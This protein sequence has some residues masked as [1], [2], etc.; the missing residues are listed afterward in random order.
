MELPTVLHRLGALIVLATAL[1]SSDAAAA[2][3]R[4][5]GFASVSADGEAL[6]SI[7]IGTPPG[8]NG[9]TP[10]LSL[11]YHHR[12]R[13][14]LLGVGWSLSGLSQI[15]RCARTYSQDGVAEPPTRT[16]LDRFCLDGQR[17]VVVNGVV[18]QAPNAEYRTEIES[19]ARI[20]AVNGPSVNGPAYFI[21]ERADGRIYEYGATADSSIEGLATPPAGG[22]RTWALNRIRDRSGNVI[23]Y[24]YTE[25]T[26]S[27][28]F[29]IASIRYNS[30][31]SNGVEASHEVTFTYKER[32]NR[33]IDSGFVAGMP[34][35]Q[36]VRLDRIDVRFNGEVLRSYHLAYE[37]ALSASGRSRLARVREC[38]PDSSDCLGPTNFEWR[39]GGSGLSAPA[40]FSA[41]FPSPMSVPAGGIWNLADVNGDGRPDHV[42]AVGADPS[43][44]TIRYRLSLADGTFG[45]AVNT[46]IA[47]SSGIGM[48]F[49]ANG[50]GRAD[51]LIAAM[52][53]RWAIALGSPTG[54][55]AA[56]DTGIGI[57]SG[58]RDFR[59]ADL[60]GDG[61]GDIAW[62]ESPASGGNT[63]KVRA[64]FAKPT[65]GFGD[66][67]TLYSQWDALGFPQ[68]EGGHFIG[69]PG[70][71]IDL[72]GD[73]AE[74]LLLN[75]NYT[76]AR[77]SD[78][79]YA[80]DRP[81][82]TFIGGVP[83]DF[84]DDGCT[85][86]AY[87]HLSS[88]TLRVRP[89]AC[90]IVAPTAD[91][92]GPAWTGN[93]ELQAIDWNGDGRD[94]VLLRGPAN[95]LVALSLGDA[96]APLED[97]GV[98][99]E[100]A[101]AIAGRDLDGDGLQDVALKSSNQV[102]VRFRNGQVPD[103][104]TSVADG[105][106]VGA[107][108]T[109][110]PLTDDAVHAAGSTA[111]WPDPH[112]Q[113]NELVVSRLRTTD[114]S[115]EGGQV[116]SNFR[117]E[118]LRGNVQGR[119]SLGFRKVTRT[120]SAGG[121][122]LSSVLTRRQD[123][124]FTGLPVSVLLQRT[125]GPLVASS[126]YRWSKLELGT[127]MNTRRFPYPSSITSRRFGIG[128][129][130]DGA[131]I[132]RI[133]R[134]IAS[135]D[136]T[137][138]LITDET[139]ATTETASGIHAGSSASVRTQHTD[140]F[141]DVANWCIGRS[142]GTEVTASHT[143]VGGAPIT[144][145]AEQTWN[146]SKCRPTR[147]RL[148]P[149]D[150]Q[151]QVTHDLAYDVFG[152]L[153]SEKITGA[154][155]VAR[156]VTTQWDA[157]GQLPT[158]VTNPLAQASRYSWDEAR[159]LPLSFTDPNGLSVRWDYDA[160]GQPLRETMPDGTSTVWER[161]TCQA[162][163][164]P[165]ARYQIR[166]DELDN[167]GAVRST[168]WLEVDQHDRGF[169]LETLEPGG[170]RAVSSV[171][172]D[173]LGR[174]MRRHLPR[175]YGDQVP[176]YQSF[177]YD[178]IGRL[179]TERLVGA[180]GSIEQLR[181]VRYDGHTATQ[182][183]ALGRAQSGTRNAWGPLA[184]VVDALG[185]R[186]SYEYDAFG[187]L[188]RVR[189][190]LGS[191]IA[192]VSYNPRG[193]KLAVDD[194]NRG[195]WSWSRNALGEVTAVRDAK[196][197]VSQFDHDALGRIT[198]RTNADGTATWTWGVAA[199]KKNIGR[200][201]TLTGPGY[202]ETFHYDGVGRPA[203]H[204]ITADASYRFDFA[205]NALGLLDSVTYPSAGT[206]SR[207]R[208]RHD[209]EAGRVVHIRNADANGSSLWTLNA[210]DAAG[211]V[212]DETL[213]SA[214]RVISGVSPLTG[215]LEYRQSGKAGGN[216]IQDLVYAW[217][218]AGNLTSRRDLNQ[219]IVEEYRYDGRDRLVQSR[220]N[221]S[222]DLELDY[223]PIGNIRRKSDICSGAVSCYAYHATRRHA[224]TAA[225]DQVYVYDANGNMTRRAG[226]AVAWS[227]DNLPV[228]IAGDEG[229]SSQFSYAPDGRRWRQVA[230]NGGMTETTV[231]A[232]GLFEKVTSG[233][234]TS[235]RHYVLAPGGTV[236]Q[237][238]YGDGS[239]PVTRLLTLD[240]A[241]STDHILDASGNVI[242]AESFAAFGGRRRPTGTGLP[243][244]AD[245]AK[246]AAVTRDGFTGHE[247]LDNLG[248]IHMNGRVYDPRL[249]RFLSA[250]PYVTLPYDSQGLNRYSYA[251]NNPLAFTD[252]SGFDP[253]P[254]LATQSGDCV[255]IT[256]IAA[257]WADYMRAVGG[258]HAGAVASALERD[259]CG[260]FGA[261]LAC[262]MPGLAQSE[263]ADIVLTVGR[264]PDATLST[265]SRL[266]AVQGFAA[267]IA[268]IAIS[269]SPIALLFGA[270]P[271]FQYFR[272]PDSTYGRAGSQIGNVGYFLGGAAGIIRRHGPQAVENGASAIARSFQGS[273]KYP[274]VDRFRDITL[275]KGTIL[276]A[277]YPG[278][279]AFF[280]TAS[281]MR[282]AGHSSTLLFGGLQ[283][284]AHES[285]GPRVRAAAYEVLE[286][287]PAAFSLALANQSHGTG[288]LPQVVVPSYT[289]VLRYLN[290]FPLNP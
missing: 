106:G 200:L 243:T 269:S 212:L 216:A 75:E 265:I 12:T 256:V 186:T 266:D 6:Y 58:T 224:V 252:P 184:E 272:E 49:D 173:A 14:G 241:G 247:M 80:T 193:M 69:D 229:T 185:G 194:I 43:S 234:S 96:V 16:T 282:R 118:E 129:T 192:T 204:N 149:G 157:R 165:R 235:W 279:S 230:R 245:L 262:S 72:D 171:V 139:T 264:Q 238:R 135:I 142:R 154:G 261:G 275:K 131:E 178:A 114:G 214:V 36:V 27:T 5:P 107:E 2:T 127:L 236:V 39:D 259:P 140:V 284:A 122:S 174:I 251:L 121:E 82:V 263:P 227:A 85:D 141:N 151:W 38:G 144:R 143:L 113:T 168:S 20:R 258:A 158:R 56:S 32:P 18:Y 181:E 34:V 255:Q 87:K 126:E 40:A 250:D 179:T 101:P 182:V 208:I 15:T 166:Q 196:G 218:A 290:D 232:G 8:T 30:N 246:I 199:T 281:A 91:L 180:D 167:T 203:T 115:G 138:G 89:S 79:E 242:V 274:G 161:A 249:G 105:L 217:D 288:W 206:A 24:R 17:L 240:H 98:P 1:A 221:G 152:N 148:F 132:T 29:R 103:L 170:G 78:R 117:Y 197:Q 62:S 286:D 3:G 31:P 226:A 26:G 205:Y 104:L 215:D 25:E 188:L 95:W 9:L 209:Y 133:V 145:A 86:I 66:A 44:A 88:G 57:A 237:L 54:L 110:R 156:S 219:G 137:S 202:S 10:V 201:V 119:G 136:S 120:E 225:G 35:R 92:L 23:D 41:Q 195:A 55:G 130:Y 93:Y 163:C 84:N 162:A 74:E 13:G 183:D 28:A 268:N 147:T 160:F 4:T 153:A 213:G 53:G 50:D 189:D 164:S 11:D 109:Y 111:G 169:R 42:F 273:G 198:H 254:C 47:C 271:D 76:I 33:E 207:F 228:S 7:P 239:A 19:F 175:W 253:I 52:N 146:G 46:G 222:V 21:V 244:A 123:F 267:R 278:Q 277:G 190:A 285:R 257:S 71:R 37:A 73:G 211:S 68:A 176:G 280:T 150:S 287:T 172:F 59:G 99:H 94:D 61:L 116:I 124:P 67:V 289:M 231:Y 134:S 260:Q 128:G 90:G 276:Y 248:L 187:S 70:R 97:T 220:R 210:Q 283:V 77:I 83:L 102:R 223:D 48:P 100:S 112:L 108:F 155:M 65:G 51:F 64:R 45:P 22:A 63:L 159:G 233:G 191:V 60:N 125:S 177:D 270:D 81:D